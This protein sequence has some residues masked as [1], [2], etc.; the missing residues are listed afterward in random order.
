MQKPLRTLL[1][2]LTATG[3]LHFAYAQGGDDA[4]FKKEERFHRIYKKYNAQPTSNEAWEKVLSNRKANTYPIQQN[5]TL[6]DISNTFFGDSNYW[7]K[8]WSYNTDNILNPHEISPKNM[9]KFYPGTL[10]EAP[11]IGLAD[12]KAA[13]EAIPEKIIEKTPAGSIEGIQIPPPKRKS[14]PLVRNLPKSLPLYRLG[15][16]NRPPAEFESDT[17]KKTI[18]TPVKFLSRYVTDQETP[19]IGEVVE[20]ELTTGFMASDFQYIIVRL[21]DPTQKKLLA[22]KDQTKIK[23]PFVL[24]GNSGTVIEI[25]G[26]IEVQ[27]K[28]SDSENLYRAIVRKIIDPLEVGAKLTPGSLQTFNAAKTPVTSSLQAR[29]IG[30]ENHRYVHELYG[31]DSIVFLNAGSKQGL[32]VD[33]SL[34]IFM[35]HRLRNAKTNAQVND[36]EIGFIK[37]IKVAD[38]FATGYILNTSSELLVGDYVGGRA[39]SSATTAEAP[40]SDL[41]SSK[42]DGLSEDDF[43]AD[44]GTEAAPTADDGLGDD[45][46]LQL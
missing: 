46:E 14:R 20:A 35:N 26:E 8:I 16:V 10:E 1:S 18:P 23:D 30:G 9:I 34:P 36:R 41:S 3:T 39:A 2:V 24:L 17:L 40:S 32:Q 44:P 13:P 6:W 43:A 38:N 19:S 37:I 28:V 11:T 31:D 7:P 27:E 42:D 25:L 45:E 22:F 15:V 29:I 4:D 5:D 12:A 21:S 33:T